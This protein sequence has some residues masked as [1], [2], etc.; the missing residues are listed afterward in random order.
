MASNANIA[1]DQ[2][3]P[4]AAGSETH[5]SFAHGPIPRDAPPLLTSH[6]TFLD[7]TTLPPR[8]ILLRGVNLASSAKVPRSRPVKKGGD[9]PASDDRVVWLSP[10]DDV[11]HGD[12]GDGAGHRMHSHILEGFWEGQEAGGEPDGWFNGG[13]LDLD[14]ADEHLERLRGWGFNVVRYIVTWESLEHAGP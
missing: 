10:A 14:D 9:G 11:A 4:A 7:T 2:H 12:A 3:R 5:Y 6:S 1:S 8:S 13:T